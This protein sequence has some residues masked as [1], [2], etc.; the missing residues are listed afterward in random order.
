MKKVARL[1]WIQAR[2]GPNY[3]LPYLECRNWED[4]ESA[5]DHFE[6]ERKLSWGMRTDTRNGS[7]QG[8]SLPF[9]HH[10]TLARAREVW[11]AHGEKLTYIVSKNIKRVRLNAVAILIDLEHIVVEWN[12]KEPEASQRTMYKHPEN[13]RQLA[14]GPSGGIIWPM[15]PMRCVSPVHTGWWRFDEVYKLMT[16]TG[17]KEVTFSV[18]LDGDL[19]IW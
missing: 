2:F 3:V 10:G 15:I 14:L 11:D 17:E 1:R 8:Y 18:T 12:D 19:V 7:T 4:V 5:V 6:N 13:L 9:V 16:Q